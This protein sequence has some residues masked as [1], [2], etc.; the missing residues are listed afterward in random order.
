MK[1][2]PVMAIVAG[3]ISVGLV[4]LPAVAQNYNGQQLQGRVSYVPSGTP[5]DAVLTSPKDSSISKPGDIFN[6]KLY[7]PLYVGSDL[8]LPANTNLEGQ[9]T[10]SD[11][12][13]HAGLNGTVNMRL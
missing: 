9:I 12:G 13:G 2:S 8:V 5:L 10:S 6:A 1:R 4:T 11:K 3:I 7:A